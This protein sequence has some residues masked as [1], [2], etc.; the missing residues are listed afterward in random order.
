MAEED[1]VLLY[2]TIVSR[3]DDY[4]FS[5]EGSIVDLDGESG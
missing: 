3:R 5:K 1:D 2:G 4:P